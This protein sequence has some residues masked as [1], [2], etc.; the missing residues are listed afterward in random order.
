[1]SDIPP[2]ELPE[3]PKPRAPLDY[4]P[5]PPQRPLWVRIFFIGCM[6]VLGVFLL[7]VGI[8]AVAALR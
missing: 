6:S 4:A 3:P 7:L 8:C 2:P 5:P 1:M